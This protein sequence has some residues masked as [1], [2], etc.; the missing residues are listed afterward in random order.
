MKTKKYLLGRISLFVLCSF[1]LIA[2]LNHFL[3]PKNYLDLIP[4]YFPNH[5]LLNILSGVCEIIAGTLMLIS[6]TRKIGACF[7]IMI[8]IAFIPAHIHLIQQKGCVSK[9]LCVPEWIAWMRLPLQFILMWWAWKTYT[10][11][12]SK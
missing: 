8:L 4:P 5:H 12:K 6:F 9:H 1:Y 7:I 10:W 11:N 3:N 2:G